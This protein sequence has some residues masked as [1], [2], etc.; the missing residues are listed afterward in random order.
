MSSNDLNRLDVH[1][2]LVC[3]SIDLNAPEHQPPDYSLIEGMEQAAGAKKQAGKRE[4]ESGRMQA[5]LV[6]LA[7]IAISC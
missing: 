3:R 6:V 2:Y 7:A 4:G 5:M 1:A